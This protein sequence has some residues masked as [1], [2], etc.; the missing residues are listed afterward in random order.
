MPLYQQSRSD[1]QLS[2]GEG[3]KNPFFKKAQHGGV[4]GFGFYSVLF[5]FY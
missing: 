5:F 2:V 4:F 1:K 3:S